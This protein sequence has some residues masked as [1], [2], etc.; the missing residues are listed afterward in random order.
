MVLAA[1]CGRRVPLQWCRIQG[2]GVLF[3][4]LILEYERRGRAKSGSEV[5]PVA[6]SRP[7][8]INAFDMAYVGHIQHG[9]WTHP[10]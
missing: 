2:T 7:I 6:M 9:M 5:L 8:R 3:F 4:G 1:I 10:R